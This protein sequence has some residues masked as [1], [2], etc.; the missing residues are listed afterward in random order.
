MSNLPAVRGSNGELVT[1]N[2]PDVMQIATMLVESR[3][4]PEQIKTPQQAAIIILKG[5]ELGLMPLQATEEIFVVNGKPSLGTKLMVSLWRRAGHDYRIVER[6]AERVTI[7]FMLKGG[8]VY[9]HTLTMAE[10][11]QAKWDQSYDRDKKAWVPKPT[12]KQMPAI[13]LTYRCFSTGIRMLDPSVLQS[14]RTQDEAHD[15]ISPDQG[16]GDDDVIDGIAHDIPEDGGGQGGVQNLTKSETSG[17]QQGADAKTEPLSRPYPPD[18]VI[19][20]V[21]DLAANGSQ[22]PADQKTRGAVVGALEALFEGDPAEIK[23]AKR[24]GLLRAFFDTDTSKTLTEG[25]CQALAA[26][27]REKLVED[28]QTIYAPSVFAAK[29]AA[30]IITLRDETMGQERMFA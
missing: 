25:Q 18:M 24:H 3:L 19:A 14:L 26:W 13:M 23:T 11:S 9:D 21:K 30:A 15:A 27:S 2:L 10:V 4:L 1:Y 6:N 29:E 17:T 5:L 7:R 8:Q 22:E 28:G 16:L 12:W 20:K